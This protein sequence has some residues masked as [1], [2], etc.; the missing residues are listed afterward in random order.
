MAQVAGVHP[1]QVTNLPNGT[2]PLEEI[3]S[4]IFHAEQ[5]NMGRT[6]VLCIENTHTIQGGRVIRPEYMDSVATLAKKHNLKIHL[7]GACLM[8]ASTA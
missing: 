4:K 7:D 5:D 8:N 2:M 1:Q 6:K 3:E